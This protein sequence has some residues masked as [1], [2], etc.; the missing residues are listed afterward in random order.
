MSIVFS[1]ILC[2][3]VTIMVEG[4]VIFIKYGR[5]D[6]AYYSLLCNVLTNPMLNLLLCLLVLV[7]GS[8]IYILAL[9]ILEI[10]VVIVEAYVYKILCN[11][12]KKEALKLS[13]LLNV[14]SYLIGL[15]MF[16]C[17][18]TLS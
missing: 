2:L 1:F 18:A 8:E 14:S 12:S 11:F 7:L 13:L 3:V 9:I 17:L 15:I 6:Y 5:R 4:I 16:K 10:I